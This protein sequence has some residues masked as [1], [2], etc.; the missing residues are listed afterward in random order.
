[1]SPNQLRGTIG[2]NLMNWWS[3]WHEAKKMRV[4]QTRLC[5]THSPRKHKNIER[6]SLFMGLAWLLLLILCFLHVSDLIR[7]SMATEKMILFLNKPST[8]RKN[9]LDT[10][11]EYWLWRQPTNSLLHFIILNDSRTA[12][13]LCPF[14]VNAT[15]L[16]RKPLSP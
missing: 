16:T 11:M 4:S 15:P 13:L 1:M 9:F 10:K 8:S 2:T 14:R 5:E 12:W 3:E 7:W 6:S